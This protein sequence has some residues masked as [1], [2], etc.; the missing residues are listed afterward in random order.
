MS[1]APNLLLNY[2][3]T[4]HT[5]FPCISCIILWQFLFLAAYFIH[6]FLF[7]VSQMIFLYV[8]LSCAPD[9]FE[10]CQPIFHTWFPCV[11]IASFY[12]NFCF[13]QQLIGKFAKMQRIPQVGSFPAKEALIVGLFCEKWPLKIAI[14]R[15]FLFL[16]VTSWEIVALEKSCHTCERVVWHIKMS[17][18][19]HTYVIESWHACGWGLSHVWMSC[20]THMNESWRTWEGVLSYIWIYHEYGWFMSHTWISNIMHVDESVFLAVVKCDIV[21]VYMCVYIYKH[22]YICTNIYM[23]VY[24]Y[25]YIYTYINMFIYI[26][27]YIYMYVNTRTHTY[28]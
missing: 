17:H 1:C 2:H 20:V 18:V 28:T 11:A 14:A 13:W 27:T 4:F 5:R 19:A 9:L 8:V 15:Q 7:N 26:Y 22:I 25:V 10:N 6:D 24:V 23:C 3:F 12:D 16:A 21:S